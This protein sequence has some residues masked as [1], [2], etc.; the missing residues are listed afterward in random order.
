[1]FCNQCGQKNPDQARFCGHCGAPLQATAAA[2]QPA[3]GAAPE[4]SFAPPPPPVFDGVPASP[5]PAAAYP[6]AES[7]GHAPAAPAPYP[8]S[9]YGPPT[10]A[11]PAFGHAH[12]TWEAPAI[13]PTAPAA[14]YKGVWPRFVAAL[15][16]GVVTCVAI[17]LL[18]SSLGAEIDLEAL[19]EG[20]IEYAFSEASALVVLV[21]GWGY[22]VLFEGLFG[23]TVGKLLLGMRVANA[24]GENAGLGR[25]LVRNLLRPIDVLPFM[26]LLGV[27]LVA[28]SDT[29]QRLGD[30][31][32]GT[33]VVAR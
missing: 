5:A 3:R 17:M 14:E 25:A 30:R 22:P 19:A 18:A 11:S 10:P 7:R 9:P 24:Q 21:V 1:M 12:A 2:A 23:A 6:P 27:I 29:K 8:A 13:P 33:Y 26:Y 32:A 31:L 20:E 15:I 28:A 16:D 4:P